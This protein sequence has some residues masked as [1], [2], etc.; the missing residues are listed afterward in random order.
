MLPCLQ[1]RRHSL[2]MQTPGECQSWQR[3]RRSAHCGELQQ[4]VPLFGLQHTS[5]GHTA[6]QTA[7]NS[8][9]PSFSLFPVPRIGNSCLTGNENRQKIW[10]TTLCY[11]FLSEGEGKVMVKEKGGEKGKTL[12]GSKRCLQFPALSLFLK[13]SKQGN[14][15]R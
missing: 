15:S 4:A 1:A 6:L 10:V 12:C 2:R 7:E 11:I 8:P 3:M 5:L 9:F 14:R 13:A